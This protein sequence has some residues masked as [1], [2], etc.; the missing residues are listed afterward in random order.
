[1]SFLFFSF[2]LL[3]L[4]NLLSALCMHHVGRNANNGM[5][6]MDI[7]GPSL[8]TLFSLSPLDPLFLCVLHTHTHTHTHT[9]TY[10]YTYT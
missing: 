5:L 7:M 2:L 8:V 4:L 9:Y 6:G 1:L 10:T 3:S